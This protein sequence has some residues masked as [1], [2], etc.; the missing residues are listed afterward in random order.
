MK[1]P[2]HLCVILGM[3]VCWEWT[4]D[5]YSSMNKIVKKDIFMG[6]SCFP[7]YISLL[8][9]DLATLHMANASHM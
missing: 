8:I 6:A 3:I 1:G 7:E 4:S 2:E 9:G 5:S